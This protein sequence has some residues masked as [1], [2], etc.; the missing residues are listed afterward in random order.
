M[1]LFAKKSL[2][3]L[4]YIVM[5]IAS[6]SLLVTCQKDDI[7]SPDARLQ[8][9]N[10]SVYFDTT[11]TG[12]RTKTERLAIRNPYKAKATID[13]IVLSAGQWSEYILN[14]NGIVWERNKTIEINANDSLIVFVQAKLKQNGHD[15]LSL[16]EDRIQVHFNGK[17]QEVVVVAWGKDAGTIRSQT[18]GTTTWAAGKSFLVEDSLVVATGD[19]LTIREGVCVY[20]KPGAN[21][22]INGTLLVYGTEKR[23]VEFRSF[24]LEH[25]YQER[26]G[27]W[28]SIIFGASSSGNVLTNAIIS[29]GTSALYLKPSN[30]L[31]ADMALSNV[32]VENMTYA[33]LMC[34]YANV[35]ATN[36]VFANCDKHAVKIANGGSYRFSHVTISN[37]KN[38]KVRNTESLVVSNA[39]DQG[40]SPKPLSFV[41]ANSIVVGNRSTEILMEKHGES[42]FEAAFLSCLA[43]TDKRG[44]YMDD[45]TVLLQDKDLIFKD[46]N[47]DFELDSASVARDKANAS[48]SQQTP[49]DLSGRNRLE[50][51]KPDLGA[52]EYHND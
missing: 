16:H 9:S 5:L 25:Y 22:I 31:M 39:T 15:T 51:G 13:K 17:V 10:D 23:P 1:L 2:L 27:M 24:R 37:Y 14:I 34:S 43:K 52:Y 6:A 38:I 32:K 28:G 36:C 26:P 4:V 18:I 49:L 8:F 11:L 50:D 29:S 19:T 20:F 47:K 7:N 42:S 3:F 48:Y 40:I 35:T 44:D 41:F 12:L 30:K 45:Q 46:K 21:F 33:G